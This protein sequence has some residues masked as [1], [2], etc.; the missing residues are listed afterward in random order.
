MKRKLKIILKFSARLFSGV[1]RHA[2]AAVSRIPFHKVSAIV[3]SADIRIA[4]QVG[5]PVDQFDARRRAFLKYAAFGGT[6]FL[7]GKY[8]N[9][10]VNAL[11]GD[12]VID[13]KVFRNFTLTETGKQLR[14]TDDEGSEILTIDKEGF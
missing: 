4:H 8:V 5:M 3:R 13:E 10:L 6:L 9:P 2:A 14:V 12:T 7:A 11:R 1:Y